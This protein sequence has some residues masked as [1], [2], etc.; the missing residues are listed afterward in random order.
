MGRDEN[1]LLTV[2][3]L[4]RR[5]GVTVRTL[6][7]Y[8]TTG[9]LVPSE[10]SEGG[11][12]MYSK[13]DVFRLHQ[14]LFLKSFG[15]SLEDIRDRLLPTESGVELDQ[16]FNHQKEVLEEQIIRLKDVVHL[17]NQVIDEI[18]SGNEI[19]ID[20][21]LAIIGAMRLGNP[22]SFII[23]D[24]S[25]DLMEYYFNRFENEDAAVIYNDKIKV[26]TAKL[27]ELYRNNEDPE[28]SEGQKLAA[29]W[30]DLVTLMTK[31]E[32][33]LIKNML[34]TGAHIDNWPSNVEDLKEATK[35]F[36]GPAIGA[37]LKNNHIKIT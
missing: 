32:D 24:M 1:N 22:F 10:Y 9:L 16:M 35:S 30:W 2:G 3:Q 14:V 28:G 4:A 18:K 23:K 31:G 34:A 27:I 33:E 25:Q 15:F 12:R 29:K 19:T 37:Y 36:L 11:R 6:Q 20:R 7:F 5:C 17:I 21:L 13:Q 8:D 26:L